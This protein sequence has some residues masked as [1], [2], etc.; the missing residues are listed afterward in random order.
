MA[1]ASSPSALLFSS[2]SRS[3]QASRSSPR[4]SSTSSLPRL[5]VSILPRSQGGWPLWGKD[6][7]SEEKVIIEDGELLQ[8]VL[9]KAAFGASSYGLVHAIFEIYGSETAGKL[10]SILSR[11]FT[12]FLQTNA[13]S[14]P[15]GRLLL[16]KDGDD[17]RR[18]AAGCR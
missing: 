18:K 10:L 4:C 9:D 5:T 13:F 15:N 11:L 14:V 16:S 3:G 12:K 2:Q 1:V 7:A 6:H 8:G 17:D